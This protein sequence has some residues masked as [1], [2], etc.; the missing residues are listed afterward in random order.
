MMA[1]VNPKNTFRDAKQVVDDLPIERW[2]RLQGIKE[3]SST[4]NI[5]RRRN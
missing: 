1:S 4:P 2:R 3:V 5:M